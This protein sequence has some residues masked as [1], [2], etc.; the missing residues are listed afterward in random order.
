ME[1]EDIDLG[2]VL[3]TR[4]GMAAFRPGQREAL[5]ALLADRRLLCIQPTGHGKSLLYQ[6]P[7]VL[8]PGMTLVI[9]PLLALV[10][11]Q[12][13]QLGARFGI[14]AGS[15]NSDQS[16][17]ENDEA[18]RAAEAGET[19]ILF[20]S[21]ERLDNTA[22]WAF[23]CRLPVDLV[24]VDE[25]HCISTWGHDFRPSYRR[26]V[27]AVQALAERR[28]GLRVL[29]LTATASARTEADIAIQLAPEADEPLRVMRHSMDRPNL[30]LATVR[31]R[32]LAEKLGWLARFLEEVEGAG[33]LYCA[34][35]EQTTTVASYLADRGLDV[36]AYHAGLDPEDKR[37]L[38]EAFTRGR[39][40]AIAAT[41][42]LGMGIDKADLRFIVHV[43]IPGSITAYYQEVG[44]AGRDGL[45]AQGIL[46]FDDADRRIQAH[47]I[48]SAQPTPE[49][50]QVVQ[51]A[52]HTDEGGSWPNL[53]Q[54][55]MRAGMHPTRL[56]VVLAEL[57]EQGRVEK[58]EVARRQI[59]RPVPG[60]HPPLDLTRYSRQTQVRT[61]ELEAMMAYADGVSGC[62]MQTLRV[63][64]GD[65]EAGPCGRCLT[66]APARWALPDPAAGAAGAGVWLMD[67][68]ITLPAVRTHDVSE[69]VALLTSEERSPLFVRFMRGRAEAA[70]LEPELL[71]LLLRR[72]GE[73]AT[74]HRFGAVVALPSNSWAARGAVARAVAERMGVPVV[75]ALAWAEAPAH[76]QGELL[77]NDQRRDNVKGK[78]EPSAALP[79]GAALVLDDYTGSGA[80]LAEAARALR[81]DA[82]FTD[83]VVPLVVA[84]VRW[85]LGARG[86]A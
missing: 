4:F 76:R 48:R 72:A 64:L 56:T 19:K 43:D 25:A 80:T 33:I 44:R 81:K 18:M 83:P 70:G 74:R 26:I 84:R 10:R 40:K 30:A 55:K 3:R 57:R 21:P 20:V 16:D 52:L 45:P 37:R 23:L 49:D 6:L 42:A 35:R 17:E 14:P 51:D 50:F 12:V 73:L 63:A 38:Q 86:I 65:D 58:A 28:P 69:G 62:A 34:T 7:A 77:N 54:V 9:S 5:E 24:V 82:G 79:S 47:F 27:D 15:I 32:G 66:C 59:Y 78:L 1:F 85:R 68:V 41:N 2:E 13:G 60:E 46:L 11:D 39:H 22:A 75:D 8:L 29:G 67:R 36:V 31:V 71:A 53:T 61:G